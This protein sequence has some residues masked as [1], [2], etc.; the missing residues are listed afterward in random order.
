[1]PIRIFFNPI[2]PHPLAFPLLPLSSMF[3]EW[4]KQRGWDF[5]GSFYV[6]A[7]IKPTD[8]KWIATVT[9]RKNFTFS[10]PLSTQS[11]EQL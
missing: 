11:K 8:N 1:M 6:Q 9:A 10:I 4:E 2:N 5:W 3:S 7:S